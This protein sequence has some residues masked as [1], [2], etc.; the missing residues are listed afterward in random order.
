MRAWMLPLLLA[1]PGAAWA[2]FPDDVTLTQLNSW[3]GD[4]VTDATVMGD[5]Y[6]TVV[7]QLGVAIANKPL[8]PAET[9]GI[10]GFDVSLVNTWSF[11]DAYEK[12]GVA[13]W[14][15]VNQD[16]DPSHVLWMPA[17]Q[18]RKG[19]PFS[20]EV[21]GTLGYLAF[22]RQTAFGAFG[23]WAVLEGYPSLAPDLTVQV[24]YSG[25][26]GNSE[27]ALGAMDAA[28]SIGYTIPFGVLRGINQGAISPYTGVG[29]V[30][31]RAAPLLSD[32]EQTELGV[33]RLSGWKGSDYYE[34]GFSPFTAH[35]GFQLRSNDFTARMGGEWAPKAL[36]LFSFSLGFEY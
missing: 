16:G 33:A 29:M 8:L 36:P 14:E 19:L 27:L 20:L 35:L 22:S 7:R 26:I 13:P 15:R 21:G 31:M 18:V 25:Y 12:D 28:V 3:D 1:S 6:R 34:E 10:N 30:K 5:A 32:A 24:G 17:L 9:L 11:I 2:G 23:R 4:A